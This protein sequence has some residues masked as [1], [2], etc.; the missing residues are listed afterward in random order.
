[1]LY[2][3]LYPLRELIPAFNV[4]RYITFRIAA[5][6]VTAVDAGPSAGHAGPASAPGVKNVWQA[7]SSAARVAAEIW[8]QLMTVP[9]S[10]AV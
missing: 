9:A 4:F 10:L 7:G 6:I 8:L 1:M 3:L 5:A 2:W